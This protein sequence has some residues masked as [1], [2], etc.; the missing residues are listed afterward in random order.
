[1][2][3][4]VF[5]CGQST[6]PGSLRPVRR[7]AAISSISG[8][9]SVPKLQ[10]RKSMPISLRPSRKKWAVERRTSLPSMARS[11]VELDVGG[12]GHRFPARDVAGDQSAILIHRRAA[13]IDG[14]LLE[15]FLHV[16]Q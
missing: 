9:W 14:D 8:A 5:S 7:A 6:M 10:N 2:C 13:R 16:G 1:M 15:A 11:L 3:T 12:V 4:A